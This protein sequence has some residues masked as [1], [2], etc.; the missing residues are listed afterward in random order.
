MANASLLISP[1]SFLRIRR[2]SASAFSTA[3]AIRSCSKSGSRAEAGST[4]DRSGWVSSHQN[5]PIATPE[6]AATPVMA[7]CFLDKRQ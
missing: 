5:S 3:K 7:C 2:K 4:S 1:S 6:E